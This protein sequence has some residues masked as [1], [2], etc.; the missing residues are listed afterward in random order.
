MSLQEQ[1]V[2]K[3]LALI[4]NDFILYSIFAIKPENE[5]GSRSGSGSGSGQLKVV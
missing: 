4:P 5:S 3:I 1:R 2:L